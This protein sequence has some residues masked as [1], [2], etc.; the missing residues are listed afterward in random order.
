[1]PTLRGWS[2]G[3]GAEAEDRPGGRDA[4]FFHE[5]A[6]FLFRLA[7]DDALAEKDEGAF[8]FV[9]QFGGFGDIFFTDDGLGAVAADMFAAGIAFVAEFLQL[10]VLG[11]VDQDGSG[12]AAA[13]NIEGFGEDGGDLCR[14]GDL[15]VPF[16]HGGGDI[17]HVGFLEGVGA[18]EV[19]EDLAGDA[20]DGVLSIM[21]SARPVTRLVAPGPLVANTTPVRPEVRA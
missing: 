20:D 4:A 15:V 8:G 17:D 3:Q 1:M 19:G 7:E 21:A 14:V 5:R 18:E 12:A 13:G 11:D 16:G 2:G 10:G 6:K 9:D